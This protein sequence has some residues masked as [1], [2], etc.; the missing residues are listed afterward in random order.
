MPY[1]FFFFFGAVAVFFD[2][3]GGRGGLYDRDKSRG[4]CG[5]GFGGEERE[6]FRVVMG[7]ESVEFGCG[8]KVLRRFNYEVCE[9]SH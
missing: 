8:A 4:G 7:R 3:G 1:T 2:V 5:F 6:E 9:G